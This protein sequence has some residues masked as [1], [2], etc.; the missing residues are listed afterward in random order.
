MSSIVDQWKRERPDIDA[1]PMALCGDV[2]RAGER[3][4]KEVLANLADSKLD[5]PGFDVLLTLRRQGKGKS[6]SPSDLAKE[7]ML[8]T[9]AM[10]NRLDRLEKRGLL[11]RSVDPNDRRGL[12]ISLSDDGFALA[13]EL[14]VSHVATEERMLSGLSAQERQQ[15]SDLL[16]KIGD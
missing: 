6:L 5:F 14:V 12:K 11:T 9:S 8:S 1:S 7:M 2:W 16:D 3:I 13:D 4:R 10:T 15:L